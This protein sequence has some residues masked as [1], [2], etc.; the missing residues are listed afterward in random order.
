MRFHLL[1]FEKASAGNVAFEDVPGIQDDIFNLNAASHYLPPENVAVKAAYALSTNVTS[2]QIVTPHFRT[3]ALPAIEPIE[4]ALLP[5]SVPNIDWY[6][7]PYPR[8]LQN[9]VISLNESDAVVGAIQKVGLL[10]VTA[11]DNQNIPQGEIYPLRATAA[12]T[13]NLRTWQTSTLTFDQ[14]IP[15]GTYSVVGMDAIGA[16]LIAARLIFPGGGF[17]PG[18]LARS[19]DLVKPDY[20]FRKGRLGE[21]GRFTNTA[22]PSVQFLGSAALVTQTVI[23]D[24]VKVA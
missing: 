22:P 10:W 24:V 6:N 19:T 3:V 16:N 5:S 8:I 21:W 4:Q 13:T 23:L 17:R 20:R 14:T 1:G 18:C 2:A 11:D 7:P 15:V 9:D 12:N